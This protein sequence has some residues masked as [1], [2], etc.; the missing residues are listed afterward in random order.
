MWYLA[1]VLTRYTN[2]DTGKWTYLISKFTIRA[3][4]VDEAYE[5]ANANAGQE[6]L[7]QDPYGMPIRVLV[8]GIMD[9]IRL[10]EELIDGEEISF[11]EN[12]NLN[13]IDVNLLIP[14]KRLLSVFSDAMLSIYDDN[15]L[16]ILEAMENEAMGDTVKALSLYDKLIT[17]KHLL[18]IAYYFKG[19]ILSQLG[20]IDGAMQSYTRAIEAN[21]NYLPAFVDRG[22]AYS[23]RGDFDNAL[24]DYNAALKIDPLNA[25]ALT[26]RGILYSDRQMHSLAI[27]DLNKAIESS[28]YDSTVYFHRAT[29]YENMGEY[30]LAIQDYT[31]GIELDQEDIDMYYNRGHVYRKIGDYG[32]AISEFR[33]VVEIAPDTSMANEASEEIKKL[34]QSGS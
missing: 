17:E 13:S 6:E 5:K 11:F 3:S 23:K 34:S 33:K 10:P 30:E 16:I 4:T 28:P 25:A 32:Q 12:L 26:N 7:I 15:Y 19:L 27:D 14:E 8:V 18:Q 31:K 1:D 20:D 9:L 24:K 22:T 29:V 2:L 21:P